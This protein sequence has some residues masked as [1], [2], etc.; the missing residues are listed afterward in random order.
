MTRFGSICIEFGLKYSQIWSHYPAACGN[1]NPCRISNCFNIKFLHFSIFFRHNHPG[2]F[3]HSKLF[4]SK[5]SMEIPRFS[6]RRNGIFFVSSKMQKGEEFKENHPI[7]LQ[8]IRT[9][10]MLQAYRIFKINVCKFF[11]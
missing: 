1:M 11:V 2:S 3:A 10:K 6:H 9:R 7:F 5:F 8:M 4:L